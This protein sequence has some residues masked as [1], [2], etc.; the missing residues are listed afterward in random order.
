MPE[1]Q[2]GPLAVGGQA[3]LEGI[4]MR[5]PNSMAV[6]CRRTDGSIVLKED[7]WVSLW[8]RMTFLRKPFVRGG[9]VL[10][11]AMWNG[12]GALT[13]SAKIFSEEEEKKD[14]AD[15]KT[16]A[17]GTAE[18]ATEK[19]T[20]GEALTNLQ[21]GLTIAFS[22]T[23]AI[24]LFVVLP[25]LATAYIGALFGTELTIDMVWFHAVDGV[26]KISVFLLYV[27]LISFMP[28]IKRTFMYHGAEHMAITAFDAG[29][30]LTVENV[31]PYSTLHPRCGTSFII[32]VLLSSILLFSIL[33]PFMPRLEALPKVL[34]HLV[35]IAIKMPLMFPIAGI[36]YE[37]IR[38][39]GKYRT[40]PFLRLAVWPGLMS[41]KI[42]TKKP[43]DDM[44]EISILSLKK[45]LW[46]EQQIRDGAEAPD[47]D[48]TT[49]PNFA[50]AVAEI[51][52]PELQ[53]E[54]GSIEIQ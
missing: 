19:K 38:L 36:S 4:M 52:T 32:I 8:N 35:F 11:E 9:I 44:L 28:D 21:I 40:N 5:S 1:K 23:A 20:G 12:I 18:A 34:R 7:R 26:I 46:R 22:M 3:L 6:V 41:Q 37:I 27:W 24:A 43:T 13:F 50:A 31:R 29:K 48:E 54:G 30:E 33:F 42:T 39:A 17:E 10:V 51:G 14:E 53:F 49:Y 2:S 45:C 47:G 25:H 15:A 16:D